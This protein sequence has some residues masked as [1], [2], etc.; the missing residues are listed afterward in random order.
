MLLE[1]AAQRRVLFVGGKGGVG[2]TS[3]ASAVA[4]ARAQ[5]GARVLLI[6]TDPAHN[7]GHLFGMPIGDGFTEVAPGL[8]AC[9]L[10]PEQT[11]ETHLAAAGRTMRRLMPEHLGGEVTKHLA[12]ARQAPGAAE[13]AVLERLA[14]VIEGAHAA[15]D[16]VV[17]DTAP[18]GHTVRMLGLPELVNAWTTGLLNRQAKSQRFADAIANLDRRQSDADPGAEVVPRSDRGSDR[19]NDRGADRKRRGRSRQDRSER[20]QRDEEIRDILVRRQARFTHLREV[21]TDR[22]H[23]AFVIVLAAERLPVLETIELRQSLARLGSEVSAL[24]VNKRSPADAGDILQRRRQQEEHHLHDLVQALPDHPITQ[25][26]LL[27]ED[28]FGR[29]GLAALI[30]HL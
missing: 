13:A 1:L 23:S 28:L 21:I 6:S 22:E 11:M 10:D 15:Y 17:I 18:S 29:A 24:V 5:A 12:L 8:D 4:L 26:P 20:G 16:L 25:V 19:G 27:P 14:D 9:E 2:K 30:K 3:I 7:L